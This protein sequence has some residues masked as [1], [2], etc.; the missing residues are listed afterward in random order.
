MISNVLEHHEQEL[1]GEGKRRV[2]A[3]ERGGKGQ[4]RKRQREK[5][6]TEGESAGVSQEQSLRLSQ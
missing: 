2:T 6:K 4:R 5:K 3:G 1:D